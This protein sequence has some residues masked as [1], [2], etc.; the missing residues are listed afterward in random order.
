[1]SSS[2]TDL[3]SLA[4]RTVVITG[5]NAGIGK[6]TAIGVA[7]LGAQVVITARRPEKG[8]EAVEE[9]RKKTGNDAVECVGLDLASLASVRRCAAE[10]L[11]RLPAIHVLDLNAGGIIGDRRQ[12]EDG[13]ESQFQVNH[14]GHFLLTELLLDRLRQSAPSRVIVVSSW[15]HTQVKH[16]LD[17]DDLQWE[18]RPYRGSPVYGATKLMNLYFTFA[19]ARRTADD[20]VTANAF[21]PGFVASQFSREGDTR[22]LSLGIAIARPFARSPEKGAR[23]GVWLAAS[24]AVDGQTGGYYIDCRP[25][26]PAAAAHD[27][28]AAER[29]WQVSEK[30][31]ALS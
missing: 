14:L 7:G 11:D 28:A 19:L 22:M 8:A 6:A 16:G 23:T 9:I 29:L 24:P 15:A 1:M 26:E 10:L 3:A 4:G 30:L 31:A 2:K 20:G 13:L 17:F 5:G 18:R 12:T 21:H 27:Q 25:A